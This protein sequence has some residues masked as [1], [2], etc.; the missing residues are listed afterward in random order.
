MFYDKEIG[1]V[2]E[3]EGYLNDEGRWV[4]GELKVV[5][6]IECDVQPFSQELARKAY[7]YDEIVQYRI[8]LDSEDEIEKGVTIRYNDEDYIV[9]K[10]V[11]WD[12]YWILL[13]SR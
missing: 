10:I 9:N 12:S 5:K 2:K 13:V 8:F 6:T 4:K 11:P 7:G 1:I 3:E